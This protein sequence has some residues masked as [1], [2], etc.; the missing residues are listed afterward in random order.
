[1]VNEFYTLITQ[2]Q[3]LGN[4]GQVLQRHTYD[5]QS[6]TYESPCPQPGFQGPLVQKKSVLDHK[7]SCH[8]KIQQNRRTFNQRTRTLQWWIFEPWCNSRVSLKISV[9]DGFNQLLRHLYYFLFT[10]WN[11]NKERR[12]EQVTECQESN[13]ERTCW[14]CTSH[15][16]CSTLTYWHLQ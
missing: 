4:K 12:P 2:N 7:F 13:E 16:P 10:S 11:R 14:T 1:M 9:V 8:K 6:R 5:S 15:C 3:T